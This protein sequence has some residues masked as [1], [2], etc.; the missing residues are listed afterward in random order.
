ME[1]AIAS[2]YGLKENASVQEA[3]QQVNALMKEHDLNNSRFKFSDLPYLNE[4]LTNPTQENLTK[5]R[6][7]YAKAQ[8]NIERISSRIN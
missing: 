8:K 4:V 1:Q 7:A 3:M 5:A 6:N 2:K